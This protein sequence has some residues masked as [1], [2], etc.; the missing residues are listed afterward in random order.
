MVTDG[1]HNS[2]TDLLILVTNV[3]DNAPKFERALYETT[4]VEEDSK[5]PKVLFVFKAYD[6]DKEV[7]NG[8]IVYRLEGQGVGEFF[9]N[10]ELNGE[11]VVLRLLHRDLPS[12]IPWGKHILHSMDNGAQGSVGYADVQVNVKDVNDNPHRLRSDI[13]GS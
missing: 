12:G 9:Q 5:V 8:R 2:T 11:I 3:N 4:V 10:D 6:V 1:K 7:M 13:Y